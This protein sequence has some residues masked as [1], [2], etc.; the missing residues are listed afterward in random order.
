MALTFPLSL[1]AFFND[2]AVVGFTFSLT[3][4]Y[5]VSETGGGEILRMDYGPRLWQGNVTL[6]TRPHVDAERINARVEA[7]FD[8]RASFLVVPPHMQTSLANAVLSDQR[9]GR[10]LRLSGLAAGQKIERGQFL[11][12]TY[13]SNPTR[14]AL[15]RAIEVGTA[16]GTG[17]TGWFEVSPAIRAGATNGATVTLSKPVC[18]A[19]ALPGSYNPPSLRPGI[20]SGASFSWRQT[21]R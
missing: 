17:L 4:S 21:L 8:A 15:H 2:L 5:E 12:F 19:I 16:D 6:N 7:L 13:G 14:Y 11:S 9:N 20:A 10:E 1:A 18:K 3:E